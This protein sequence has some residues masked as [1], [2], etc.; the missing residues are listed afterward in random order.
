MTTLTLFVIALLALVAGLIL[1]RV[2]PVVQTYFTYRGK[3]LVTCPETLKNVAVDL[4]AR[5]AA[6]WAFVGEPALRS[7]AHGCCAVRSSPCLTWARTVQG[8]QRVSLECAAVLNQL[9]PPCVRGETTDCGGEVM[10]TGPKTRTTGSG[11]SARA[12]T[13][14]PDETSCRGDRSGPDPRRATARQ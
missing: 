4:A 11:A 2:I 5:K 13:G 14:A 1:F 10:A 8:D 7:R 9:C 6:T 3:R 12:F